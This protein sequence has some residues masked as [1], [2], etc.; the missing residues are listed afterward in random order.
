MTARQNEIIK[1]AITLIAE[2]GIQGL[3]IKNL[4]KAINVTEPALYRHFKNKTAI[5]IAILDSFKS[6]MPNISDV[7]IMEGKTS[8]EKI[9]FIFN[10]YFSKF[11]QTPELVSVIFSDEIFKND[12]QLSK[13]IANLLELN[14]EMFR[15]IIKAGQKAN[16]IREDIKDIHIAT[17]IMGSLRLLVKRWELNEYNFDLRKEGEKMFGSIKLMIKK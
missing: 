9:H 6:L 8:I 1:A 12:K 16:E 14:E 10:G 17:M 5:L 4:A 7:I 13:K 15:Q 2:K 3:T 11:S